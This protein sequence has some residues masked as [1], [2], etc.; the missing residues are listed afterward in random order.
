MSRL[1]IVITGTS[2]GFGHRLARHMADQGHRVFATMREPAGRN[3]SHADALHRHGDTSPGSIDVVELD[4]TDEN[5][6]D[7]AL[8]GVVAAA[9]RIDVLVNNAGIWG[10]GV[11]E[12]FTMDQWQQVFDVNVMGSVR[13]MRA[14]LP[15]MR[16]QGSGLAVQVSSL[17]GR[18]I[19]PYSG[20]YVASKFAVE[21]MAETF[22]Y[23]VAPFGIEVCIV[24][25]GDFMTEMKEKASGY[26]AEDVGVEAGYAGTPAFVR[27]MYLTPDPERSGDPQQVVDAIARLIEAP[28]GQRRIR[29][30]VGNFL[31]QIEQI[32]ELA[33]SMH[34]G[35]FPQMGLGH[36]LSPKTEAADHG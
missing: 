6:T 19:L 25:P 24:E 1:V 12:A 16:R 30:T 5:S 8:N 18:F 2:T 23:E 35:L 28:A 20:P 32:N 21:A 11:L 13:A 27:Q 9:G 36:L 15:H 22:R 10:P 14:A 3:A 33:D 31:P 26:A 34:A 29:T 7:A 4:V 17:Q